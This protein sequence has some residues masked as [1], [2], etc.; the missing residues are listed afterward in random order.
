[1]ISMAYLKGLVEKGYDGTVTLS[2]SVSP[3]S[4]RKRFVRLS[5]ILMAQAILPVS[6]AVAPRH[7]GLFPRYSP[8]LPVDRGYYGE[9]CY[10]VAQNKVFSKL[11]VT[12]R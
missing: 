4:S 10:N 12:T 9:G 5:A 8:L 6:D 3:E 7:R 2:W 1:L 11:G